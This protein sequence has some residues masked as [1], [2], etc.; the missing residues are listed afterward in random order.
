M[1]EITAAR[2]MAA[3]RAPLVVAEL[4]KDAG[5]TAVVMLALTVGLVGFEI[6]DVPGGL[7]LYHRFDDVAILVVL[8]FFGRLGFTLLRKDRPVPV[9]VTVGPLSALLLFALLFNAYALL[10][11]DIAASA[12]VRAYLPFNSIIVVWVVW[13]ISAVMTIRAVRV[14]RHATDGISAAERDARMD[15]VAARVQR[16]ALY[17]GPFLLAAVLNRFMPLYASVNSFTQLIIKS[18]Q[19]EGIWKRWE[20]VAGEQIVL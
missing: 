17:V 20:P 10:Q 14:W 2:S 18:K 4:L 8:A 3:E 7:A 9:L 1:A 16:I 11:D 5:L 6:R 12:A 19:R 13:I 15:R